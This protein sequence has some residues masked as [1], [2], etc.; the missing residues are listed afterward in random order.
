M[1]DPMSQQTEPVIR[2][3][4]LSREYEPKSGPKS[5]LRLTAVSLDVEPAQN[6]A[7]T[8]GFST[9][10]IPNGDPESIYSLDCTGS[11]L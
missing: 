6:L 8:R 11:L 7:Q 9:L 2:S 1:A 4:S 5:K 10:L 3:M